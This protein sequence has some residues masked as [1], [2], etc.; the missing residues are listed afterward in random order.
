MSAKNWCFT[1]NNP[2]DES[3]QRTTES[4]QR[5]HEDGDVLYAVFQLEAG[6]QGTPHLQGYVQLARKSRMQTV[7]RYL[8]SE[9]AHLEIARG[10][11]QQNEEYCSKDPRLRDTVRIGQLQPG[12]G[13]RSDLDAVTQLIINGTLTRELI[14]AHPSLYVRNYRGLHQ[15]DAIVNPPPDRPE[16][17]ILWIYGASGSGKSRLARALGGPDAY[18]RPLDK[19][20]DGYLGDRIVVLDDFRPGQIPFDDLLRVLDRYPHRVPIKGG[21][22]ALRG[23]RFIFTSLYDPRVTYNQMSD[24]EYEQIRRRITHI[25]NVEAGETYAWPE[26]A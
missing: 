12:A 22:T 16:N 26:D 13:H 7:K 20:W 15:L 5:S 8:S 17:I 6:A 24:Y 18:Y 2:S 21:Y 11:P 1:I 19:W 10:N 25:I 23:T 14:R 9:A 4:L 3:I